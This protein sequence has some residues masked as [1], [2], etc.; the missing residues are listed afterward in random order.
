MVESASEI[1][2]RAITGGDCRRL[3]LSQ[4][5]A[6]GSGISKATLT[7]VVIRREPHLQLAMFSGSQVTHENLRPTAAI[8]R[9]RQLLEQTFEQGLLRHPTTVR[10]HT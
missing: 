5:R 10:R 1:I 7:P 6:A 2:E 3:L 8:P 9:T 4:P